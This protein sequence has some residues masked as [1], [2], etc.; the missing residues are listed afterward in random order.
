MKF[1]TEEELRAMSREELE[2]EALKALLLLPVEQAN[3]ILSKYI[4]KAAPVLA[5]R[6]GENETTAND[7]AVIVHG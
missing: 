4:K 6:D 2:E 7:F 1:K 5:H 3:K